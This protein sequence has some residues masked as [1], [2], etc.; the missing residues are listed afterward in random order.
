MR[1]VH[2]AGE[3]KDTVH[4]FLALS[5]AYQLQQDQRRWSWLGFA[6]ASL[7]RRSDPN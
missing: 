5:K 3:L 1:L 6:V 7:R 2:R 4:G